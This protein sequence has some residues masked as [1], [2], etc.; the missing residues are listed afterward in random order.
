MQVLGQ[1]MIN[2]Y[3]PAA[4][5]N[6]SPSGCTDDYLL[7]CPAEAS[8]CSVPVCWRS[9]AYSE[10]GCGSRCT[11]C[12]GI[13]TRFHHVDAGMGHSIQRAERVHLN[14]VLAHSQASS[15][16]AS[17]LRLTDLLHLR[18]LVGVKAR[19]C[20][21]SAEGGP[22]IEG[23]TAPGSR[24]ADQPANTALHRTR[25]R[26]P[27]QLLVN[28]G[29]PKW[30]QPDAGTDAHGL[31]YAMSVPFPPILPACA[32]S[33]IVPRRGANLLTWHRFPQSSGVLPPSCSE[34]QSSEEANLL[35]AS[36]RI[37][38]I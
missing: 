12:Y 5:A 4:I 8:Y 2:C 24:T 36:V 21:S 10:H 22:R 35:M 23:G 15:W 26:C 31:S 6:T 20:G 7:C 14:S 38:G 29:C 25:W 34:R 28:S 32:A 16:N 27:L 18:G 19:H 1:M 33:G 30:Q 37:Y 13:S 9:Y 17:G 11:Y 3:T